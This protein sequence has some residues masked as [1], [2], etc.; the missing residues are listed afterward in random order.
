MRAIINLAIDDSQIVHAK[1]I[2]T[3]RETWNARNTPYMRELICQVN[4]NV[5]KIYGVKLPENGNMI[6]HITFFF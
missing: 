1:G 3:A 5:E 6:K 2:N 4:D